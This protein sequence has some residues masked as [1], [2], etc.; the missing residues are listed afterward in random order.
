MSRKV[1]SPRYEMTNNEPKLSRFQFEIF[2]SRRAL[3]ACLP[4]R[5]V[6]AVEPSGDCRLLADVTRLSLLY[7]T[8]ARAGLGWSPSLFILLRHCQYV[9][10]S[11]TQ[12][13]GNNIK[14]LF[15]NFSETFAKTFL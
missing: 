14:L 5:P 13:S 9:M 7:T 10:P 3:P 1:L 6:S 8:L 15:R 12:Q 2:I 4:V 11:N